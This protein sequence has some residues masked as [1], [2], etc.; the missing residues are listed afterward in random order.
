M[1]NICSDHGLC[2]EVW[3]DVYW[4]MSEATDSQNPDIME[5]ERDP[6][7]GDFKPARP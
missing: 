3:T 6:T 2:T 5:A 1:S 4:L 7:I